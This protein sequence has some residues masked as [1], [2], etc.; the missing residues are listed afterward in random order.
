M[1]HGPLLCAGCDVVLS[2]VRPE[3]EGQASG[4]NNAL[5]EVG[6]VFGVAVL[7]AIFVQYGAYPEAPD[8]STDPF[9]DGLVPALWVGTAIL[10]VGAVIA[11]LIPKPARQRDDDI[12]SFAGMGSCVPGRCSTSRS[13]KTPAGPPRPSSTSFTILLLPSGF[14]IPP[15]V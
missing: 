3:E 14:D 13:G 2:A 12:P 1:R 4:A 6:G 7:A 9:V 5:R 15:C 8:F 10:A 11:L